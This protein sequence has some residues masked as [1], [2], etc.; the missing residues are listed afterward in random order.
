[1]NFIKGQG[2]LFVP[3]PPTQPPPCKHHWHD[4]KVS[5]EKTG[6]PPLIQA[7]C[8]RCGDKTWRRKW[9]SDCGKRDAQGH[10]VHQTHNVA[11]EAQDT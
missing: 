5:E 10:M 4:A 1:M 7:V 8:C 2:P 9:K 11:I 3:E 6:Y